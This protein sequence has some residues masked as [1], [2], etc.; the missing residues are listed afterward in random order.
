LPFFKLREE[1]TNKELLASF[2]F[3]RYKATSVATK[4]GALE[5]LGSLRSRN[6]QV[7]MAGIKGF[8]SE[9]KK[10]DGLEG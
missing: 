3:T 8:R 7:R 5:I 1:F 10:V 2:A 9:L 4:E 6:Y